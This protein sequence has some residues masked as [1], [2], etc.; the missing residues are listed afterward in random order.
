M[1]TS[2]Y[3]KSA[4]AA[5]AAALRRF[6]NWEKSNPHSMGGPESIAS[7]GSIYEF[8]PQECRSP[9]FDPSGIRKMHLALSHIKDRS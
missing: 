7:V 3:D 9:V 8:L 4:F 5:R 6:H 1:K 2:G